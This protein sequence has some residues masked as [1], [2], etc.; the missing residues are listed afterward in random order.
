[1]AQ[2]TRSWVMSQIVSTILCAAGGERLEA[3]VVDERAP[4][5]PLS[6]DKDMNVAYAAAAF[7]LPPDTG[8]F[9][10]VVPTRP[11]AKGSRINNAMFWGVEAPAWQGARR[12][13]SRSM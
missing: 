7:T 8:G 6:P 9:R 1:M 2:D 11:G 3:V 10:H 12:A 4:I 13:H 5:E